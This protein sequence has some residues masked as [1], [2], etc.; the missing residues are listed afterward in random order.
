MKNREMKKGIQI[1]NVEYR[2]LNVEVKTPKPGMI[3]FN[4]LILHF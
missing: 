1:Q 3:V 4:F 2:I